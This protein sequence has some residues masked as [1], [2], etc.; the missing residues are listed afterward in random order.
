MSDYFNTCFFFTFNCKIILPA[1][2]VV[3]KIIIII[4]IIIITT[5]Q[6]MQGNR[7]TIGQKT[8]V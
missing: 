1:V 4:I 8:L 2:I 7:G 6:C 5:L 3:I